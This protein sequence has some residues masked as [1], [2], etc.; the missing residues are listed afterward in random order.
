VHGPSA[1]R[2][3]LKL[4]LVVSS[5]AV[6]GVA[7]VYFAGPTTAVSQAFNSYR[8]AYFNGDREG[9][10]AHMTPEEVAFTEEQRKRA[11][12]AARAEVEE[13]P[14]R[15]RA[16]VLLMRKMVMNGELKQSVLES[17]KADELYA[18]ILNV[19]QGAK[20]LKPISILFAV[21]TGASTARGYVK[22]REGNNTSLFDFP[23]AVAA[24]AYYGFVRSDDGSWHVDPSPILERSAEENEYWAKRIEPTGNTFLVKNVLQVQDTVQAERLFE[25]LMKK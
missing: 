9:I 17:S 4:L 12:H 1:M 14:F 18:A 22:M 5:L 3:V 24:N 13:L 16:L 21:P 15:K 8:Q 7:T 25:P 2:T 6:L 11:L 20:A 19:E 10:L 23:L